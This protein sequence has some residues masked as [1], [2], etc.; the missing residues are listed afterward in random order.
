[1]TNIGNQL[2]PIELLVGVRTEQSLRDALREHTEANPDDLT[3]ELCPVGAKDWVAGERVGHCLK[4]PCLAEIQKRVLGK[5]NGLRSHQRI[6]GESLKVYAIRSQVPV[7][8][9]ALEEPA[10]DAEDTLP[11]PSSSDTLICP[12]CRVEVHRYNIQCDP[13]GVPVGCYLCRGDARRRR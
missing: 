12:T 6:R 3:L 7:F 9:D 1:M 11:E 10:Q 8:R 4:F 13:N 5:L 2:K